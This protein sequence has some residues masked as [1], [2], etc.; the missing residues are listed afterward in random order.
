[1]GSQ[2]GVRLKLEKR[3]VRSQQRKSWLL[4]LAELSIAS[5]VQ[6]LISSI[7]QT[8]CC[9]II[10]NFFFLYPSW[11]PFPLWQYKVHNIPSIL[12]L[13]CSWSFLCYCSW[14]FILVV[15]CVAAIHYLCCCCCCLLLLLLLSLPFYSFLF[16][17]NSCCCL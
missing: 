9:R 10:D 17:S 12:S 5:I 16:L 14:W 6:S 3:K 7:H 11:L 15:L 2:E 13:T 4:F 8:I 1:M